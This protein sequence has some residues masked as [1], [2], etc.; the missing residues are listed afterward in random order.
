MS[1]AP[2]DPVAGYRVSMPTSAGGYLDLADQVAVAVRAVPGVAGLHSGTFGEVATYLPGRR[3]DGIQIHPDACAVHVVLAWGVPVLATAD[4]VRAV[5]SALL[6]T[7][8]DITVDDVL[9]PS[10]DPESSGG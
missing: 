6:G 10:T 9:G 1:I 5:V 4:R 2:F 7:R 3:V 8:V